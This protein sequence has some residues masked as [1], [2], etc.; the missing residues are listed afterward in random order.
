MA[1]YLQ[2]KFRDNEII[3]DKYSTGC[4]L[5]LIT[6]TVVDAG[7]YNGIV[8]GTTATTRRTLDF[9][10]TANQNLGS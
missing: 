9:K 6:T 10:Y 3:P 1:I 8:Y 5:N 2:K 4:D 7:T